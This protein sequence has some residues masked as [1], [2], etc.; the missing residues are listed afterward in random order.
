LKSLER[1][2]CSWNNLILAIMLGLVFG[3]ILKTSY[4]C[5]SPLLNVLRGKEKYSLTRTTRRVVDSMLI[6][7]YLIMAYNFGPTQSFVKTYRRGASERKCE[8]NIKVKKLNHINL[9]RSCGSRWLSSLLWESL[10]NGGASTTPQQDRFLLFLFRGS[11][12]NVCWVMPTFSYALIINSAFWIVQRAQSKQEW[13]RCGSKKL[14]KRF[15]EKSLNVPANLHYLV[16][17]CV[18]LPRNSVSQLLLY[19]LNNVNL[20]WRRFRFVTFESNTVRNTKFSTA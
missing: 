14:G 6:I 7:P 4:V 9:V 19:R 15:Y 16:I 8:R 20:N 17:V 11:S 1:K 13:S 5:D 12:H 18:I 2:F 3:L 10:K